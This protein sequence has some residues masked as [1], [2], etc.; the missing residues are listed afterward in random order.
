M[1]TL[2][3]NGRFRGAIATIVMGWAVK[4]HARG[5][6]I[7]AVATAVPE[8]CLPQVRV[9]QAMMDMVNGSASRREALGR[10]FDQ[11]C[12]DRRF[13]VLPLE[14]LR[15]PRA[16][17]ATTALY[18]ESAIALGRRAARECLH[19]A[20][21][22]A[23]AVDLVITSSC[24]GFMIPSFDAY[25]SEDLGFRA[26]TRR[27]PL[28]ELGC[29][30]GGAALAQAHEFLLAHPEAHVLIVSVE[31]P[32]L[33][34]H[35][36]DQ[37]AEQL[38]STALFG[39][40]AAAVL[41]GGGQGASGV[42]ILVSRPH[43][44][45]ETTGVLGFDLHDD[46]L[47]VVLAKELPDILRAQLAPVVDDLLARAE[48]G[49]DDLRSCVLHPGGKAILLGIEEALALDRSRTQPSWD[50]LREYGNQS[51]AGVLFVL[52][53]WVEGHR[54]PAGSHGLLAA[55][56]PGLSAELC[57]LQWN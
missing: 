51:S 20:G 28:T 11:T 31:L 10:L 57:L 32:T 44:F 26:D 33:S 5:S 9:K 22:D 52:E 34:F 8:H 4:S 50:V 3:P 25:L 7:L 46:G 42:S 49:R 30:G 12:V 48:I 36:G 41:L 18:R 35:G 37:R 24:T 19:R 21:V 55:F 56:G 39:D 13:S 54:P 45:P 14:E 53:R 17:S 47:H 16:L 6:A 40:G 2:R 27:V 38:V 15:L 1:R 29:L 23:R 43:R